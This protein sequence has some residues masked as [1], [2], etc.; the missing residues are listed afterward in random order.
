MLPTVTGGRF[1]A[2]TALVTSAVGLSASCRELVVGDGIDAASEL[3]DYVRRCYGDER[4]F[5]GCDRFASILEGAPEPTRVGFLAEID[6]ETCLA[7]CPAA[8]ACLDVSPYCAQAEP[9]GEA[10][11]CCGWSDGLSRCSGGSCCVPLGAPCAAEGDCC[12]G[13]CEGGVCGGRPCL[14]NAQPC[15]YGEECCSGVCRD[16]ACDKKDCSFDGEPCALPT[17]CCPAEPGTMNTCE[18][19]VCQK[20]GVVSCQGEL[21]PC[22]PMGG[23]LVCCDGLTCQDDGMGAVCRSACA[24]TGQECAITPCCGDGVCD[25]STDPPFCAPPVVCLDTFVPCLQS[26]E[27]CSGYCLKPDPT[28]PAGTCDECLESDCSHSV[29]TT[30]GPMAPEACAMQGYDCI[31]AVTSFDPFCRCTGWDSTCL[32][33]LPELCPGVCG[34]PL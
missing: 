9:C 22:E 11:D 32:S 19:G 27:C 15:E 16:G 8:L 4:V 24:D 14:N 29:C 28:Q 23:A 26:Y 34:D 13:I 21:E 3:C 10:R 5:G 20:V 30:G 31:V 12:E 25:A 33:Y 1:I 7:S 2:A 18:T 6:L 17:D